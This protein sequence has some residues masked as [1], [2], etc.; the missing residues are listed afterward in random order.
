MAATTGTAYARAGL[1]GN[2][3]DGY[4]GK[5]I[6]LIVR[7]FRAS[8]TI[9]E[10]DHFEI[11]RGPS[12]RLSYPRFTDLVDLLS[13]QGCYGGVRLLLG[14]VRR[15]ADHAGTAAL[16]PDRQRF[17]MSYRSDIPR[18]VG[19]AGSSA[20]VIAALRA[21]M[22]WFGLSIE[23]ATLAELALKAEVEDLGIAAGPMDRVIQAYEGVMLM[24]FK[25]PRSPAS[26]ARLDPSILPPLFIAYDPRTGE[27]SGKVHSDV[28]FRWLR[29]DSDVREAIAVFP[30]LVDEGMQCLRS[31]DWEGFRRLV[32]KNFDTRARIWRLSDRDHEMIR[33]GRALGSA[34]KFCGSGGAVIGAM[35]CSSDFEAIERAYSAAGYNAFRPIIEPGKENPA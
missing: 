14:A 26:Y 8:V 23:P 11:L 7:N 34:V 35:R 24:D 1:L 10:S 30:R 16:A 3:S 32:D 12:D 9:E 17:T 19:M 27:I 4:D 5:A 13:D 2:P 22:K 31:R 6:A 28:R 29:G 20:L 18:Q 33:I 25:P 21:M 15:F